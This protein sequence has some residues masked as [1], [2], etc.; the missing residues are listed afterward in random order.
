MIQNQINDLLNQIKSIFCYSW[1]KNLGYG[2]KN[3]FDVLAL[4]TA[5]N[6]DG[7]YS[8]PITGNFFTLTK[9]AVKEFQKN[10]ALIKL[11]MSA[12]KQEQN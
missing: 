6:I 9:N 4:Q 2:L 10:T 3:N 12:Q 5:L 8:G 1:N 11:A 7:L